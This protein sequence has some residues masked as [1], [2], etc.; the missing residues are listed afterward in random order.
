MDFDDNDSLLEEF[1][2][3]QDDVGSE[4]E[5]SFGTEVAGWRITGFLG[6]GGS[7]E[8][9]CVKSVQTGERAALKVL[10]R[11]EPQQRERFAREAKI[12]A[13]N[14]SDAFPQLLWRGEVAGRPSMLL[15]LLEPM[16]LPKGD[17]VVARYVCSV[18][19]GLDW[20]HRHGYIHRDVKP[21]NI[22]FRGERT[23]VLIDLGLVKEI[24]SGPTGHD[25]TLSI[26]DGKAVGVGTPRYAAPEQFTGGEATPAMDVHALGRLAYECFD[27][28]PPRAWSRIIR[29]ATS[30][31]PGE[32]YQTI[33]EFV[34]AIHRRHLARTTAITTLL[35]AAVA[36]TIALWMP[37]QSSNGVP[38]G[39]VGMGRDDVG[40]MDGE[41][42]AKLDVAW[43]PSPLRQVGRAPRARRDEASLP[44][45]VTTL[46]SPVTT[47]VISLQ[48]SNPP[49]T[50]AVEATIIEL[51]GGTNV[52]A[53][54]LVLDPKRE[55]WI[56]GPGVLDASFKD[57]RGAT[58]RLS[59][60]TFLNRTEKPLKDVGVRY[61][62]YK[63]AVLD[64]TKVS[65]D[66]DAERTFISMSYVPLPRD[67]TERTRGAFV[68][69]AC[70]RIRYMKTDRERE[71]DRTINQAILK[72]RKRSVEPRR[73]W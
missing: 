60:C 67:D 59:N 11:R 28:H 8:V 1:L 30:S 48:K 54:P 58:M 61:I 3:R 63:G 6:R 31:I 38:E 26:V 52:F 10:H 37:S 51:N 4:P 5:L 16:P 24:S 68:D 53:H 65:R 62:L 14:A 57:S 35:L 39:V 25:D 21:R 73:M 41:P 12:L 40:G 36:G 34:R 72:A 20:L 43:A 47:N 46:P 50:S 71:Y 17:G 18:A 23:P 33:R 69:P 55:Y 2:S 22:L 44:S 56:I 66:I 19:K 70:V 15:E 45:P 64:F 29:R 32:R 42:V 13:M 49:L 7:S 27:G 9:Y